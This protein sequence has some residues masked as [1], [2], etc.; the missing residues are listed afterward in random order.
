MPKP[1]RLLIAESE[2]PAARDR[3][4]LSTGRSNGETFAATLQQLHPGSDV[5]L[6]R[7]VEEETAE[8]GSEAL[9]EFD[10][11]FLSGSPLHAWDDSPPVQRHKRFMRAVFDSGTPSF[12]S[13]AGLQVAVAAT[14]GKVRAKPDRHEAGL[15]RRIVAT[16]AG[17]GHPLLAGRPGSWDALCIH[18]DEVETLPQQA[19]LLAGNA[20]TAVQAAEIR[21]GT[22]TFWGVQYHPEL[23]PEEVADALRRQADGLIEQGLA[24]NRGDVEAVASLLATLDE[25]PGRADVQWRLGTNEQVADPYVRMLELRNFLV[26]LVQPTRDQR[27]R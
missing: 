11:V 13:C 3:R 9:G 8:W 19:T 12:G 4:R 16:E 21:S 25:A 22:G 2:T 20:S 23:P 17:R 26:H 5:E 18:S 1:L 24:R 15:A 10:G 6:T 27:G 7:P 14:G